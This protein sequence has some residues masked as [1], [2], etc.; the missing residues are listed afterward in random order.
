MVCND[1]GNGPC[2]GLVTVVRVVGPVWT[3]MVIVV[4]VVVAAVVLTAAAVAESYAEAQYVFGSIMKIMSKKSM[5]L[6]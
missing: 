6:T 3:V 2:G 1:S 5:S 4:I